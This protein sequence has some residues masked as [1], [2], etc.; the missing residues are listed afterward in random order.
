MNADLFHGLNGLV[1]NWAALDAL[2]KFCAGTLRDLLVVAALAV[3]LVRVRVEPR[4]S[5]V[6]LAVA[7]ATILVTAE[8]TALL[9]G[10]LDFARPFAAEVQVNLLVS[11]PP[12]AAMPSGHASAAAAAA[13]AGSLSWPRLAPV[14]G[15][16]A[17]L[18]GLGRVFV[19]V[20]YPADV[21][22]GF[23]V[24]SAVA[25]ALWLGAT[26]C[27]SDLGRRA[28]PQPFRTGPHRTAGRFYASAVTRRLLPERATHRCRAG[29]W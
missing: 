10:W 8:M 15:T 7:V 13:M 27:S 17:L 2:G 4:H 19:G 26:T 24:G 6:A 12:S 9:K 22:A 23:A 21:L 3:P 18:V 14:F 28:D 1:G 29:H 5:A 25:T 20:H 16:A 11:P